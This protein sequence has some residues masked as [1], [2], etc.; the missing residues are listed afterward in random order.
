MPSWRRPIWTGE[1][2]FEVLEELGTWPDL[3]DEVVEQV[4]GL[5]WLHSDEYKRVARRQGPGM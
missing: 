4:L 3:P 2:H 5:E 1:P